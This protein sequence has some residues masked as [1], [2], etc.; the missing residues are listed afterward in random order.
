MFA[1]FVTFDV[2]SESVDAFLP[3]MKKQAEASLQNEPE[4]KIF[5]IWI[6]EKNPTRVQLYEVYSAPEDFDL[7][8]ASDHFKNFDKAVS[9]MILDKTI[10]TFGWKL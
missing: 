8:L 10:T 3:L 9:P 4:C 5:E 7:H 2:K 6:D 1:A